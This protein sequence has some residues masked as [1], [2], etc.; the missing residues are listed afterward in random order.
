L[1]QASQQMAAELAAIQQQGVSLTA[2]REELI[3]Q[4]EELK[5]GIDPNFESGVLQ[6]SFQET[7]PSKEQVR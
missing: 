6:F 4:I 5:R 3:R 7:F 1:Q 2:E